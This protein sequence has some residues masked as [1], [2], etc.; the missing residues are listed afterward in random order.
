MRRH[1]VV[2]VVTV[3]LTAC[4][5]APATPRAIA[6]AECEALTALSDPRYR[7]RIDL[8]TSGAKVTASTRVA[9]SSEGPDRTGDYCKVEAAIHPVDPPCCCC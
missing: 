3:L 9:P 5:T 7:D 2:G 6:E 8:P 4:R 1:L